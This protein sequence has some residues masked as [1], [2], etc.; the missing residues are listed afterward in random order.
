MQHKKSLIRTNNDV[1]PTDESQIAYAIS[2][3]SGEESS[4]TLDWIRWGMENGTEQLNE[5]EFL[6]YLAEMIGVAEY[7]TAEIDLFAETSLSKTSAEN[8]SF[9]IFRIAPI[10]T[11]R[12][13]GGGFN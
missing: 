4:H 10:F 13:H 1:C 8:C 6:H 7:D 2:R 5:D 9:R 12:T 3:L 11:T